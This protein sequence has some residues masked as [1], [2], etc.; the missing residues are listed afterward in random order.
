VVA[1]IDLIQIREKNLSAGVLYQLSASAARVTRGSAT[2]L[3]INDRSDIAAAA[4]ADGVH[5][6]THSLPTDVVRRT[7]GDEFLV[8]VSTH[9]APEGSVARRSE[10]DFVVFGPVF[11]TASKSEYGAPQG[12]TNLERICAD[13]SPFPVLALGGLTINNAAACIRAGAHGVAGISMFGNPGELAGVVTA[14]RASVGKES[15]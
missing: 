7:F 8:G 12:L 3:L 14:I 10:A 5:L 2:K 4:G 15:L 1:G 13:L 6:T 11:E 9:S